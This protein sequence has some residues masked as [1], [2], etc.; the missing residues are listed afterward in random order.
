M[1]VYAVNKAYTEDVLDPDGPAGADADLLTWG[2]IFWESMWVTGD[3][4]HITYGNAIHSGIDL[5]TFTTAALAINPAAGLPAGFSLEQNYPN[6]FNP[7]TT[8]RF[9]LPQAA[10]VTLVVYDLLGREVARLADGRLEAGEHR[11]V[12]NG[13]DARGREVPTGLYIARM[14]TATYTKSIKLVLLK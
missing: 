5:F 8:L 4:V 9:A 3:V 6:P 10:E 13:R 11:V 2:L 7:S 14:V 12:W 1:Y